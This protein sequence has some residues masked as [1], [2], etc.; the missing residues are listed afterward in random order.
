MPFIFRHCRWYL[1]IFEIWN[2]FSF[3]E[4]RH[5]FSVRQFFS[6][7]SR[8]WTGQMLFPLCLSALA[9]ALLRQKNGCIWKVRNGI[10]KV[11]HQKHREFHSIHTLIPAK[12]STDNT[13]KFIEDV[14][15]TPFRSDPAKF[16][17]FDDVDKIPMILSYDGCAS[18]YVDLRFKKHNFTNWLTNSLLLKTYRNLW[19][20]ELYTLSL[21]WTHKINQLKLKSFSLGFVSVKSKFFL[22]FCFDHQ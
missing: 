8:L 19:I 14:N 17:D 3:P 6:G 21:T 18:P 20:D 13:W 10:L 1:E 11:S 2:H 12:L 9:F 7:L 22:P 15:R 5:W 4:E 16:F